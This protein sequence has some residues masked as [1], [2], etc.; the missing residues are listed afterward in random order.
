EQ[1]AALLSVDEARA[2]R[3]EAETAAQFAEQEVSR[4]KK[5]FDGSLLSKTDYERGE[6]EAKQKRAAAAAQELSV[7][8]LQAE[9]QAKEASHQT[10]AAHLKS[11][12]ALV[13]GEGATTTA[14]VKRCEY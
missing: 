14:S 11:E 5:L 1:K 8:R 10:R 7:K 12:I 9:A 4:L 6:A 3:S 2:R 13:E